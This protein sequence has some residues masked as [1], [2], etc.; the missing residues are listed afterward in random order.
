MAERLTGVVIFVL[1]S[2]FL[3][4]AAEAG[5]AL[6]FDNTS[7]ETE[8][9]NLD[10]V[11]ELRKIRSEINETSRKLYVV[12]FNAPIQLWDRQNLETLKANVVSYIPDDALVIEASPKVAQTIRM[13]SPNVRV[14]LSYEP[15]WKLSSELPLPSVLTKD[16]L[17]DANIKFTS[18][19]A[20]QKSLEQVQS[21]PDT[22]IVSADAE[23]VTLR[24]SPV[25]LEPL[26]ALDTVVWI[27]SVIEA[28]VTGESS[29]DKAKE[30]TEYLIESREL[31]NPSPAVIEG[32]V[33]H[34]NGDTL[35]LA[36]ALIIDEVEGV[37]AGEQHVYPINVEQYGKL[38][39][40]LLYKDEESSP[41]AAQALAN[42]LDLVVVD[43]MG[44]ESSLSDRNQ[45]FEH[46]GFGTSSGAYEIRIKGMNVPAGKQPYA[47]LVSVL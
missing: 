19:K 36:K 23:Q 1:A 22:E 16:Q 26:S 31:A 20:A 28:A 9:Q 30:V 18:E 41:V 39:V 44:I 12:Q 11:R 46:V 4:F 17:V 14:V 42:D 29:E 37:S 45:P 25:N 21:L 35:S 32:A 47:L 13:S 38:S 15:S 27:A 8:Q 2:L 7:I 5:S 10:E 43:P 34:S 40:T 24:T 33:R 3:A 6:H